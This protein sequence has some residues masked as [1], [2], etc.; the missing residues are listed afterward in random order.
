MPDFR[1]RSMIVA[2][3]RYIV[4]HRLFNWWEIDRKTMTLKLHKVAQLRRVERT[5]SE[6]QRWQNCRTDE[7]SVIRQ[8]KRSF[9]CRV[10]RGFSPAWNC[11]SAVYFMLSPECRR[12]Y[13]KIIK[14]LR[15]C[16]GRNVKSLLVSIEND[17]WP[18]KNWA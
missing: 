2:Y 14:S 7:R 15:A 11:S 6:F 18:I 17:L 10:G 5:S 12:S 13:L 8:R 1:H 16:I 3:A 4:R 9:H